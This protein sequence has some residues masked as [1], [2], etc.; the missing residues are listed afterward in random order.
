M[1]RK[2]KSRGS[3]A[4]CVEKVS[5]RGGVDDPNA[6]CA[7]SKIRA[8]E[9]LQAARQNSKS[10]PGSYD[11][12]SSSL[13][14]LSKRDVLMHQKLRGNPAD[15]AAEAF[16]KFHGHPPNEE[17]VFDSVEHQHE[18]YGD[19]GELISLVIVPEG[20]TKGVELQ[21][22]DNARLSMNEKRTQLYIV[23]GDQ[24]LDKRTL[25]L[26]GI[27]PALR[28]EQEVLGKCVDIT[29][30]TVK[31]H[32]GSEGGEADYVHAFAEESAGRGRDRKQLRILLSP[33]ATYDVVNGLIGLWG[34]KYTLEPEGIRN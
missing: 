16:E 3:F 30:F 29:Y 11:Y 13:P 6:V 23:G 26:F 19:I 27:D 5:R 15:L 25:K 20:E 31:T 22:F 18:W 8:G 9:D 34:G 1:K 14:K 12:G 4:R 21:G 17:I 28:H 33:T 24:S 7:A 2:N 10:R 32:L